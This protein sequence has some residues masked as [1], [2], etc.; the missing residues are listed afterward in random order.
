[1]KERQKQTRVNRVRSREGETVAQRER[2]LGQE[3][4]KLKDTG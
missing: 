3:A 4:S 2:E 1:M